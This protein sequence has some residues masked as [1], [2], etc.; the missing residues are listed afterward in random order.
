M[1][2]APAALVDLR[3]TRPGPALFT[4]HSVDLGCAIDASVSR[5]LRCLSSMQYQTRP[6]P[7]TSY[8][9]CSSLAPLSSRVASSPLRGCWRDVAALLSR[10]SRESASQQ[11]LVG[12]G[13]WLQSSS[14]PV[15]ASL[16]AKRISHSPSRGGGATLSPRFPTRY[17]RRT[18]LPADR[19]RPFKRGAIPSA[20]RDAVAFQ[21]T[22]S[23]PSA[24]NSPRSAHASRVLKNSST[25]VFRSADGRNLVQGRRSAISDSSS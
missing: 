18:F 11:S 22:T 21:S 2:R 25:N 8:C 15:A 14:H 7:V 6:A 24:R 20:W 12:P 10:G 13:A 16:V 9:H 4:R 1:A 17:G 19:S 23:L 5:T 3:R